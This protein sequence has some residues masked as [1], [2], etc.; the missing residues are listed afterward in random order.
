M[1]EGTYLKL[2]EQRLNE[3][4][5][6]R[7]TLNNYTINNLK[8]LDSDIDAVF[9]SGE[10]S[11]VREL[12]DEHLQHTKNSIVALYISGI[13]AISK[14]QVDDTNIVNLI[15]IFTD[16]RK[17][18]IVEFLC[19]RILAFGENKFALK[20]LADCYQNE[21]EE[22]KKFEIWE[23]LIR[24][25]YEEADIVQLLAEKKEVDGDI[26]AAVETYK[27]AI[28]RYIGKKMFA[29][30]KDVYHKLISF[31][32]EDIDFFFHVDSKI[33]KTISPDRASQLLEDLYAYYREQAD[34]DRAIEILKRVLDYDSK[35]QWARKEIADCYVE[36]YKD[37]S[38]L[39]EYIRL[40]N[41]KQ[42]WRNVHEAIED[43]EKHIAFDKGN[44][45]CHRSWGVG[46]IS[47]IKGDEITIDFA[48]KRGHSMSLKMAVSALSSLAKDHIWVLRTIWKKDQLHDKVKE[49]PK[50]ALATVIRSHGN[51]ANM[52]TI[53]AEIAP[54]ILTQGEWSTWSTEARKILK[55]DPDFGNHPSQ[56]DHYVVRETPISYEEKTFNRFTAEKDFFGRLS[57][58]QEF[59]VNADP[60]SEFF[61]EMFDYFS[62][63]LRSFSVVNESILASYLLVSRI[64]RQYPFLNPG[65]DID[66]H[67]LYEEIEDLES[68][69]SKID[70]VELKREFL[71]QVKKID[72]WPDTF[73]RLFPDYLSKHIIDDL[74]EAGKTEH[75]QELVGRIVDNYREYR[76]GFVWLVRNCEGEWLITYG[77]LQ[78][79]VFIGMVHLLDIS[80]REIDNRR[81][82]SE[83]RRL[84]RQ[85]QT[86]LFKDGELS[87]FVLEADEE[88]ISRI[89]NLLED[90]NGLDPS[91]AIELRLKIT[92]RFPDFKFYGGEQIA[93]SVSMRL[94]VTAASYERRQKELQH[95]L[96]VEVPRNSKEIG[97]AIE[98]GDLRENAEYKAA[99]EKQEILNSTVAKMKE[100]ME[101][102]QIFDEQDI[103]ATKISYG[104]KVTLFN[105]DSGALEE[106][107]ILGPWESNPSENIISYLSPF[108]NTLWNHKK[109]E[110]LDFI[111]NNRRY[112]YTVNEIRPVSFAE[113]AV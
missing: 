67:D 73:V 60:E 101:R 76:E 22:D 1:A 35:N 110:D 49:E 11:E 12:C 83:N 71:A 14:Q 75:L 16:N 38:E 97:T 37:H 39:E 70:D 103:D 112:Q 4:K 13:I 43:F 57:T 91:I 51:S 10:E 40:S 20:T 64:V 79:K 53:K 66:F 109:G 33:A 100:E 96:E 17:W 84:N 50:W 107:A 24:V 36:K 111:I 72:D 106:Y 113:I 5:W 3:E 9:E 81:D 7:A 19:E 74:E 98:M 68:L 89:Y 18:N 27:K 59:L 26:G 58:I 65:I 45:V 42:A 31:C 55:T 78:E 34:W 44:F 94:V 93:E 80:F 63:F 6:T 30:V 46:I 86:Y 92:E 25:D 105:Q 54:S 102:A 90:V 77:V 85:I 52:K 88:P 87:N 28:H 29:N 108:G 32:P 95:I 99:K 56:L 82:V 104:T 47:S 62:S 8:E 23:R 41:L 48:R 2:I 21:N 15:S 69:F 61:A